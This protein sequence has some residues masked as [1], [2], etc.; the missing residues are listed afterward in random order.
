MKFKISVVEYAALKT[1]IQDVKKYLIRAINA[2][3]SSLDPA[4][5]ALNAQ[6]ID[7]IIARFHDRHREQHGRGRF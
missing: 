1:Q 4:L 6:M 5:R 3:V 2:Q 7:H